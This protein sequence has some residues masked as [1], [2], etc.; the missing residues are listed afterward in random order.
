[1][2]SGPGRLC[3]A[4]S[5]LRQ[6]RG[7]EAWKPW[8]QKALEYYEKALEIYLRCYGGAQLGEAVSQKGTGIERTVLIAGCGRPEFPG[9][10]D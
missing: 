5:Q 1:M 10:P 6:G 4:V 3:E 8:L 2:I 7:C 9:G